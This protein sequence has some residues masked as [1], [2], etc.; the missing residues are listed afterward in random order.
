MICIWFCKSQISSKE[1]STPTW[2]TG[3]IELKQILT[4]VNARQKRGLSEPRL[5]S[6]LS[7]SPPS[8]ADAFVLPPRGL[9]S[10]HPPL[11]S[12]VSVALEKFKVQ[13][14]DSLENHHRRV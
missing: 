12:E 10:H 14:R 13:S 3:W 7:A 9:L 5:R 1:K 2:I 6:S 4:K 8:R 11:S